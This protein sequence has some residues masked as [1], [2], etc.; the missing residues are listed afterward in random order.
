MIS[1]PELFRTHYHSPGFLPSQVLPGE[2]G[3]LRNLNAVIPWK[4]HSIPTEVEQVRETIFPHTLIYGC[5]SW[6]TLS[7]VLIQ[8][9]PALK[10]K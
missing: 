7:Q 5:L 2:K 6:E 10:H 8:H 9:G 3:S 1:L 4:L